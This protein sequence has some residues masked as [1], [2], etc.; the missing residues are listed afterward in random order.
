[1]ILDTIVA[2]KK[3]EVDTLR[4]R[5]IRE[6]EYPIDPPRG[7]YQAITS[8]DKVAIIA[9]AKKAMGDKKPDTISFVWMQGER[10]HQ[11]DDTCRA[12]EKNLRSAFSDWSGA[13]MDA[14]RYSHVI[15]H[16]NPT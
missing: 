5:G 1:M 9:E 7:F 12:Y 11:E 16:H 13:S 6:P 15:G 4:V 14:S 8:V 10:D 2:H 3:Q